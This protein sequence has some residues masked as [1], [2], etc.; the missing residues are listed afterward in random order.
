V[1]TG[2]PTLVFRTLDRQS[3]VDP[4]SLTIG[5]RGVLVA[6]GSFDR[7]TGI[8]TFPLPESVPP[9]TAGPMT[10]RMVSSDFQ[11]AK[12][13]DTVGSSI[14]PNTRT[15]SAPLRVVSG[16]A[17][18]WL[19]PA[20]GACVRRTQKLTVAVSSPSGIRSV[21]FVSDGKRVG[22]DRTSDQGLWSAVV[23]LGGGRHRLTATAVDRRGRIAS[24]SLTARA[25]S[26]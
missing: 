16:A 15:A 6:V 7:S 17:V 9:L 22:V 8:A 25:C 19:T 18:D 26:G 11:E 24:R 3:G 1:S 2:R 14:M 4:E 13:V 20:H 23:R 12:N 5:Y 21:R 10:L